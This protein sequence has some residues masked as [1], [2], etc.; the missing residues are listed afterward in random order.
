MSHPLSGSNPSTLFQV[1]RTAGGPS[2]EKR[3]ALLGICA[4]VLCRTPFSWIERAALAPL[5]PAAKDMPPPVFILGHWRSGTTHLYNIMSQ[6]DFGYVPPVATGMPWD[7]VGLGRMLRP[8]LEKALPKHRYIDAIPVTPDSPQEDEIA[9]ASMT[10][11]SFYHGIYF[12]SRF[13]EHLRAGLFFEGTSQGAIEHRWAMC[14]YFLRK[15]SYQQDRPMLIKNPVYTACV[16][17][18]VR[19][20]PGAKFIH[21]HRN[22][23][24]VFLSMR[25]FYEKLLPVFALQS[26]DHVD[27]EATV[28][29]VYRE[30]MQRFEEQTA[31]LSAPHFVE[32]GYDT[33]DRDPI[34]AVRT[35]YETLE[36]EG[37][38]AAEPAFLAYLSTVQTYKKNTFKG[39]RAVV[40]TV[41]REWAYFIDKWGYAA[42]DPI[43]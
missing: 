10:P 27:I 20:F 36:I 30:M 23:F 6:G 41:E 34:G 28:L 15:L 4:S 25:N 31:D 39:T 14:S 24:D 5:L 37:F 1:L 9:L 11:L 38:E 21:I 17:D 29:S 33:L 26:Y 43:A 40:E 8:V 22:P 12:P 3:L 13:E 18:L 7:F 35:I 32:L 16:T 19:R 42:P 2:P